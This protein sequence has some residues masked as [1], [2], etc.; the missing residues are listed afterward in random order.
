M[1]GNLS[2]QKITSISNTTNKV[3]NN[4]VN[5]MIT[6]ASSNTYIGQ[7]MFVDISH[8]KCG[9]VFIEQEADTKL[10]AISQMTDTNINDIANELKN[11]VSKDLSQSARQENTGLNL[12]QANAAIFD[13]VV[14]DYMDN[15]VVND[16]TTE[17][18]K[19]ISNTSSNQ[20]EMT[21]YARYLNCDEFH[22]KQSSAIEMIANNITQTMIDNIMKNIESNEDIQKISQSV[23]QKNA[24]I[25]LFSG[26]FV[27]IILGGM[28]MFAKTLMKYI[29][30]ILIIV[31]AGL[32]YFYSTT[33]QKKTL[34]VIIGLET[35]LVIMWLYTF[36]KDGGTNISGSAS[37]NVSL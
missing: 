20:Q 31:G 24:G 17:I 27:L 28:I 29:L 34:Y 22:A 30:P 12:G 13:I 2:S 9:K 25:T 37:G 35:I 32:I 19:V 8:A 15:Q 26:L 11:S 33:N 5:K 10:S 23:D 6:S 21:I 3:I 18:R 16:V 1:G 36:T 14:K 4:V 7:K